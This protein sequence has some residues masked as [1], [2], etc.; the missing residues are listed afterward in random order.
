MD[1]QV[2][3]PATLLNRLVLEV[4][5]A[6]LVFLAKLQLPGFLFGNGKWL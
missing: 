5:G 6:A 1:M 4:L 3:V 2:G